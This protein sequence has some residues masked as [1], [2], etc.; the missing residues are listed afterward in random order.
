M[1]L[2]GK[3]W[4][5][6]KNSTHT[7]MGASP[8]KEA[9]VHSSVRGTL[10][11]VKTGQ[12]WEV[13]IIKQNLAKCDLVRHYLSSGSL[14]GSREV[15]MTVF[16]WE[17]YPAPGYKVIIIGNCPYLRMI[18]PNKGSTVPS[19][20][21]FGPLSVETLPISLVI[22]GIQGDCRRQ[23]QS[24]GDRCKMEAGMSGF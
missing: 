24:K 5:Y 21:S 1:C 10:Y 18:C 7:D 12:G 2:I 13:C 11:Q 14:R 17:E 3:A 23:T 8:W 22:P 4:V 9:V 6:R 19:G 20:T 16:I 15:I